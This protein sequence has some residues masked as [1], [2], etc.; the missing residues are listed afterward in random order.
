MKKPYSYFARAIRGG[1]ENLENSKIIVSEMEKYSIVL[2]KHTVS[3]NVEKFEKEWR[4]KH[5]EMNVF[6]RDMKW[7]R[8]SKYFVADITVESSGLGYEICVAYERKIPMVLFSHENTRNRPTIRLHI[9]G[10][11]MELTLEKLLDFHNIQ[12]PT[13]FYNDENIKEIA[14]IE[15]RNLFTKRI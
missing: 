2:S 13:I 8:M 10:K 7:L 1:R 15:I 5:P 12:I 9:E 14:E 11:T 4:K 6:Q 3:N